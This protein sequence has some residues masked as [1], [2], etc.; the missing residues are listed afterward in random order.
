VLAVNMPFT[1]VLSGFVEYNHY[2]F[3]TRDICF[4][5]RL[6]GLRPGFLDIEE[7]A[8]AVRAGLNLR[9]GGEATFGQGRAIM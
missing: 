8:N 1:K 4:R 6:V 2:D 7:T 5:P 3:A 9:L